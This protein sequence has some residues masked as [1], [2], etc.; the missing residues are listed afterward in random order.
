MKQAT[1]Y[2]AFLEGFLSN[3]LF[4]T[5]IFHENKDNVIGGLKIAGIRDEKRF[6]LI[7][8]TVFIVLAVSELPTSTKFFKV[9]YILFYLLLMSLV[10]Q[11]FPSIHLMNILSVTVLSDYQ[12]MNSLPFQ[13]LAC[14]IIYQKPN[15]LPL[16]IL[17]ILS[18]I[19]IGN[20]SRRGFRRRLKGCFILTWLLFFISM[21][22]IGN[23]GLQ[24]ILENYWNE[25]DFSNAIVEPSFGV[26]WYF[27]V[28]MLQEY[29][30]FY[31]YLIPLLPIISTFFISSIFCYDNNH[32]SVSQV[33]VIFFIFLLTL[34]L[35]Y[36][37]RS[38]WSFFSLNSSRCVRTFLS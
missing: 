17:V 15:Y 5:F 25:F 21:L 37:N 2:A 8:F 7:L 1:L 31:T 12:D 38:L 27:R 32:D 33:F 6:I 23:T 29:Y 34:I 26:M 36:S 22:S 3:D 13:A 4:W 18:L 35:H 20:W 24:N 28:L 14:L 30:S 16:L 19:N 11:F 9:I 10:W